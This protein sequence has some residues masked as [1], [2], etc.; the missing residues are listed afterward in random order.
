MAV[1]LWFHR[2]PFHRF[3]LQ[4]QSLEWKA[5][6]SAPAR[7]H[8]SSKRGSEKKGKTKAE[9]SH[10]NGRRL[11]WPGSLCS[12]NNCHHHHLHLL[13][14]GK[15]A[16]LFHNPSPRYRSNCKTTIKVHDRTAGKKS[17][18]NWKQVNQRHFWD[19]ATKAKA[20]KNKQLN[21]KSLGL[22]VG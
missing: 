14:S 11:R 17:K 2:P 9:I 10:N 20:S 15:W 21:G 7:R 3:F 13:V 18:V 5:I 6:K 1:S 19:A 22:A 12:G 4:R 16:A 8:F